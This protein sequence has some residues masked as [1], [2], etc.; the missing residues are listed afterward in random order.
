MD[1]FNLLCPCVVLKEFKTV[2]AAIS[3]LGCVTYL[4]QE[5]E[6]KEYCMSHLYP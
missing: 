3:I 5:W 1:K 2:S 6:G 4:S